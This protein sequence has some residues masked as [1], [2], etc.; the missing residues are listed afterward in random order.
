MSTINIVIPVFN[1]GQELVSNLER[2]MEA[3]AFV[4]GV[5]FRYLLVNDGSGD[6]TAQRVQAKVDEH[7]E[8]ELISLTRNFG[9]EAAVFAGLDHARGEAAIVMD[10][11][12]QHPPE[13]IPQIGR[14]HV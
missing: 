6:D 1:E 12:L 14:A 9:K 3:V 4:P 5:E 13:L 2:I 8:L 10:S 11:D 7:P